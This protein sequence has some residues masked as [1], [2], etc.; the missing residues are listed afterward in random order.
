MGGGLSSINNIRRIS[1]DDICKLVYPLYYTTEPVTDEDISLAKSIWNSILDN[2]AAT[3]QRHL[4]KSSNGDTTNTEENILFPSCM[5]M[6]YSYFYE[7]LFDIHPV[8]LYGF[9]VTI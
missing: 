1:R 6:F 9:Y 8:S 2:S 4:R 7:R 5:V 3:F